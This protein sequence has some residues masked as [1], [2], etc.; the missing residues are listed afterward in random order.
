[1]D[2]V[3]WIFTASIICWVLFEYWLTLREKNKIDTSKDKNTRRLVIFYLI[4]AIIIGDI[5]S[6]VPFA[7]ISLDR[8]FRFILGTIIVWLGI[9]L[10][11]WS[12]RVLGNYFRTVVMIQKD[13]QVVKTG[14][15]K[16][17]RHPSYTAGLI[18]LFGIGLTMGN[19]IGLL[20][21]IIISMAGYQKRITVEES[22]LVKS[23]GKEYSDYMK[24][25]KR[26]V[27]FI[28]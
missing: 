5:F 2:S 6:N 8:T 16:F 13:H 25:T 15:Y 28:Y 9:L 11:Y 12:V 22:E 1:M 21:M 20:L 27:P 19:W 10:R 18:I 4:S 24:T 17:I 14:P 26:L 23:L 7:A 3:Y